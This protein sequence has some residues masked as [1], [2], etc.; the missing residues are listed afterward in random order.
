MT[1]RSLLALALLTAPGFAQVDVQPSADDQAIASR[2]TAILEATGWFAAPAVRVDQGVV[3]LAGEADTPEHRQWATELAE[4]TDGAVAAVNQMTVADSPLWDATQAWEDLRQMASYALSRSPLVA[5]AL[6]LL[7]LTW[8]ATRWAAGLT[9]RLLRRRLD[10]RLSRAVVSRAVAAPVFLLGLYAVLRISGLTGVAA[11]V[12]GGAGLLGLII[13]FA[14]RDI[15]ENFLASLMLSVQ[16]PFSAGD[17]IEVAGYKGLVQSVNTR[18]TLL[19]TLEGNHIQIPNATV[20]KS[21]ITNFTA[22]PNTRFDFG[23]GVGNEESIE[24]A[25]AKA[26]EAIRDQPGLIGDPEPWVV[27]ESLGAATV[28]LRVYL[29]V[30]TA[31]FNGLKV[32]SAAIRRVKNAFEAAGISMPDEARE[33]VFPAGVPV[34]MVEGEA[35]GPAPAPIAPPAPGTATEGDLSAETDAIEKQADQARTPEGGA[36]LLDQ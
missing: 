6:V 31:Q 13:G 25:Q 24:R 23:V 20:Y 5:L 3:F 32:R 17:L 28:N 11:T 14:F 33:I 19:M 30:N 36:N 26:L 22:N 29:W 9:E 35:R 21:T 18:S 2:L 12:V 1:S 4:R 16:H 7:A 15:A 27:V 8:L 34:R 10:S